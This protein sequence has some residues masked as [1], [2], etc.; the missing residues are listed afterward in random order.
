[1]LKQHNTDYL[2]SQW[3]CL[4]GKMILT[5]SQQSHKSPIAEFLF[6]MY[7]MTLYV[8]VSTMLNSKFCIRS[9]QM[10]AIQQNWTLNPS[11]N[12]GITELL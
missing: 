7:V 10:S 8:T 6:E 4:C 2:M 1:M 3:K 12:V 11:A 5:F 9:L